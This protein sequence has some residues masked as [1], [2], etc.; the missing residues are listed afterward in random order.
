MFDNS[1][2]EPEILTNFNIFHTADST[3]KIYPSTSQVFFG[4]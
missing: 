2:F 1:L 4:G 3:I